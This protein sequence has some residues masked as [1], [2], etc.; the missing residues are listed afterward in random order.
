MLDAR[1][2]TEAYFFINMLDKEIREKIPEKIIKNI[3]QRMDKNYEFSDEN[4]E[5][6]E[7]TEKILSVIY[8]DYL[9]TPEEKEV[10]LSKERI[11]AMRNNFKNE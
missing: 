2:Y 7:D 9:S 4:I 8:T 1:A 3:E 10:I 11:L 5:L 6:L